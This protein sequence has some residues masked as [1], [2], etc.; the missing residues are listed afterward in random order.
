MVG[1]QTPILAV[2]VPLVLV[3]VVDGRRGLR[4]TWLPAVVAGLSFGIAQFVLSN[5][6]SVQLGNRP[7]WSRLLAVVLLL[8]VWQPVEI[9]RRHPGD[10]REMATVGGERAS[11]W[12]WCRPGV[13][14]HPRDRGAVRPGP[15]GVA[16]SGGEIAKAY[17]PYLV[18]IAIFS[19][20]KSTRSRRRW[21]RSRSPMP[22]S[23][24]GWT[25][26]SRLAIRSRPDLVTWLP[27]VGKL[28]F[29]VGI[30]TV[31]FL[32]LPAAAL[33]AY[34]RLCRAG[35]GIVT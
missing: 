18:I 35:L 31:L 34:G 16:D 27:A 20:A 26:P 23:G 9:A 24:R 13:P 4:Q 8:R 3:Q 11:P 22:S 12:L 21:R 19:I 32:S 29:F 28:M 25:S 1:R 17:A 14:V 15:D 2:V 33:Q 10:R 5:Y 7:S 30:I 6:I